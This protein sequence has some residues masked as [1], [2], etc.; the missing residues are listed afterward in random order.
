MCWLRVG[1]GRRLPCICHHFLLSSPVPSTVFTP[2]SQMDVKPAKP[3]AML[4]TKAGQKRKKAEESD[5]DSEDNEDESSGSEEEEEE[6]PSKPP[7]SKKMRN[8][9]GGGM[10]CIIYSYIALVPL[11]PYSSTPHLP[12]FLLSLPPFPPS[13][14]TTLCTSA[15]FRSVWTRTL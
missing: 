15:T 5:S 4:A 10:S 14:G 1:E 3:A 6:T 8:S 2:L 9:D 13:Q 12:T 7:P 11:L